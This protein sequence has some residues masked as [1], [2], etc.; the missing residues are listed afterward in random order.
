MQYIVPQTFRVILAP[1]IA[2]FTTLLKDTPL[3]SIIGS[4]AHSTAK[5]IFQKYYNPME[6]YYVIAIVYFV[7][8]YFLG[9]IS[10]R[11]RTGARPLPDVH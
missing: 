6:S 7:L 5:I 8:N 9:Q 2:Q 10:L 1:L 4:R 11:V 3:G